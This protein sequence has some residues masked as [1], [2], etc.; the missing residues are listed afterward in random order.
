MGSRYGEKQK[1][2]HVS[3]PKNEN[4]MNGENSK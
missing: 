3:V 2:V 1:K 4:E